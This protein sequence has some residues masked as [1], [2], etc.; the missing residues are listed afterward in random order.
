MQLNYDLYCKHIPIIND[1]LFVM[2]DDDCNMFRVQASHF[3][4]LPFRQHTKNSFSVQKGQKLR[5]RIERI[6][7]K[8][9]TLI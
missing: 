2:I 4:D 5:E 6:E 1:P 7:V 3:V 9:C 8:G